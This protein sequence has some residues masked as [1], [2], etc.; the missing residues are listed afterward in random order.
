M[1]GPEDKVCFS[2]FKVLNPPNLVKRVPTN[3]RF[4][5]A[6]VV[7][8]LTVLHH[9]MLVNKACIQNRINLIRAARAL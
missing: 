8:A 4:R 1:S 2:L 7:K 5:M 6:V 3:G 9:R